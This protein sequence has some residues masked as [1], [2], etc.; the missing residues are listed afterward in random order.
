MQKR[1]FVAPSVIR[2]RVKVGT[3]LL[4]KIAKKLY[5]RK[6]N[7]KEKNAEERGFAV[8]FLSGQ[9]L[10]SPTGNVLGVSFKKK[11]KLILAHNYF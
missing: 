3:R 5:L 6:R 9:V 7:K 2:D 8:F 10:M 1:N 4:K 11:P